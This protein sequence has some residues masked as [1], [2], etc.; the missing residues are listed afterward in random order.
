MEDNL[1]AMKE[2]RPLNE[3][4]LAAV[5]KV[6]EIFHG[7]NLIP[8]T[9]CR[10]CIEEN[11]CPKHIR[12][13][14]L[15]AARNAHEAFHNWNTSY[16]YENVITGN[17]HGRASEC[18]QCGKCERVCPQHLEIRRLLTEVAEVFE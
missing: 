4:E 8:C 9:A 5:R 14:D 2:F 10:Y 12:I 3:A 16:Y 13:P 6:T 11:E 17:G 1:S 7:L 18:I 15:F